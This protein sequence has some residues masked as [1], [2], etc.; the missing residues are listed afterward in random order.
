MGT[1]GRLR[2]HTERSLDPTGPMGE[3]R[4]RRVESPNGR[5]PG[6][7]GEAWKREFG[8]KGTLGSK[9]VRVPL[10]EREMA[11]RFARASLSCVYKVS[12]CGKQLGFLFL[13]YLLGGA[14]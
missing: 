6:A 10:T 5:C 3:P 14:S 1:V 4:L 11:N 7:G 13:H 12:E 9:P 2:V 8:S